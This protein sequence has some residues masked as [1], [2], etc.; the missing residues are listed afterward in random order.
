MSKGRLGYGGV[1]AAPSFNR[2]GQGIASY[3]GLRGNRNNKEVASTS[4]GQKD[5]Y[6][7]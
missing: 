3:W 4:M 5:S 2:I 1:A 7:P 6:I